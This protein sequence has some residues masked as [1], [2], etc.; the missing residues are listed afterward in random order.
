MVGICFMLLLVCSLG[1]HENYSVFLVCIH[2]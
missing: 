2:F 1:S